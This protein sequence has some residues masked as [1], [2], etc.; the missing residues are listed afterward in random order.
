[1][2]P[3]ATSRELVKLWTTLALAGLHCYACRRLLHKPTDSHFVRIQSFDMAMLL[4]RYEMQPEEVRLLDY[5]GGAHVVPVQKYFSED[6]M[7][8]SYPAV[9][10]KAMRLM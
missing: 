7:D 1:M 2:S 8:A 10:R 5:Y 9:A 4:F 6:T 3:D